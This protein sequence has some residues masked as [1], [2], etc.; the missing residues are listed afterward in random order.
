MLLKVSYSCLQNKNETL[1]SGNFIYALPM[2]IFSWFFLSFPKHSHI[3][4]AS[5]INLV[6][7]NEILAFLLSFYFQSHFM[8][9]TSF[10]QHLW[11]G[12]CPSVRDGELEVHKIKQF[13][14][15]RTR[16]QWQS[17]RWAVGFS[18]LLGILQSHSFSASEKGSMWDRNINTFSLFMSFQ[19][20]HVPEV[21]KK[22]AR[23]REKSTYMIN[24]KVL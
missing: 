15:R 20:Y 11:D 18:V 14:K 16:S 6:S 22:K 5:D 2:H 12:K 23:G 24:S 7:C 4:I 8:L 1:L 17:Q 13:A 19:M 10:P 21:A 3:E 9:Q